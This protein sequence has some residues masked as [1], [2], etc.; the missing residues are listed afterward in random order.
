VDPSA[1][2]D[3]L[4]PAEVKRADGMGSTQLRDRFLGRRWM[5]RELLAR[6]L[7]AAP[8]E[9]VLERRCERCGKLHP[10]SP[11]RV[12]G[13]SVWWSASASAGL[14]AVAIA[15]CRVGL[16]RERRDARPRWERIARRFFS[17]EE[18][19][20]AA[21]SPARFLEFW[22]LK[23]AYLKAIGLGLPGGLRSF[24]C[25]GLSP[26]ADGWSTTA[27]HPGWSFRSLDPDPGFV[28]ALAIEGAA[29]S[30]AVRRWDP[31]AG[32]AG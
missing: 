29:D 25:T 1:A 16:D 14:A 21:G 7:E 32:G 27:A 22:T 8:G 24:E 30:I 5:A 23:E 10:A 20:A 28:G 6:E 12:G 31:E 13:R 26:S 19:A 18:Q 15:G 2:R 3:L 11:L 4:S 17:E 9:L